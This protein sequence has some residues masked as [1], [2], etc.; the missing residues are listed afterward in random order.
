MYTQIREWL[1][2]DS[3]GDYKGE[4]FSEIS[5]RLS[6]AQEEFENNSDIYIVNRYSQ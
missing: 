6:K 5:N 2:V 4:R 1:N 3:I